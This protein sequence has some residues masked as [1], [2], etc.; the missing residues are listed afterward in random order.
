[1]NEELILDDNNEGE[2]VNVILN[3]GNINTQVI[4][5]T[6]AEISLISEALFEKINEINAGQLPVLPVA[7]VSFIGATGRKNQTIKLQALL[8]ITCGNVKIT[9]TFFIAKN[10]PFNALIGCDTLQELCTIIDLSKQT[11]ALYYE[12]QQMTCNIVRK[13]KFDT[14]E[15]IKTR[16]NIMNMIQRRPDEPVAEPMSMNEL[17][18]VKIDEIMNF[19]NV[20]PDMQL[21]DSQLRQLTGIYKQFQHIFSNSPGKAKDFQCKLKFKENVTF[22]RKSYPI[23]HSLKDKVHT[24]IKNMLSED[25][26]EQSHSPYTSPLVAIPKKDGKVRLCLDAKEI[27]RVLINDRTSPDN[28]DE[29]M[30]KFHNLK[31]ITS[32][33]TVC[34]Y[35]QIELHPDSRQYVAFIFEG[36]NY[37]FKSH[38]A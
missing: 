17:W 29:I 8:D 30:K 37:Q 3:I 12:E 18:Q 16:Y 9:I 23:A 33:D 1:M 20:R 31:Y 28:I 34:R 22:N 26:I 35:W 15:C 7:N 32:W 2:V 10:I 27:N 6:G 14:A 4:I 5:D 21:T 13:N 11:V 19:Q 24:E 38:S 25:I 36:R